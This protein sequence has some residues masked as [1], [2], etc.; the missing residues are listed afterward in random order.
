MK[1]NIDYTS[2]D[3]LIAGVDVQTGNVIPTTGTAYKRGDL[4][5]VGADNTATHST[6]GADWHVICAID[7]TAE[8]VAKHLTAKQGIP[9]YTYGKFNLS[10]VRK[11]GVLLT[12]E[13]KP[14]AQARGANATSITLIEPFGN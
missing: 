6:N 12:P 4:L 7:V 5:V 13:E 9:V 2:S 3:E 10:A 11:N 8:Q 1:Q 14:K